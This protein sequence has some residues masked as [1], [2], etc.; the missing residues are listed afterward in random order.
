MPDEVTPTSPEPPTPPPPPARKPS[1]ARNF[2]STVGAIIS[3]IAIANIVFLVFADVL[4]NHAN[5]YAGILAYMVLPAV[6]VAGFVL[7]VLGMILERRRRRRHAPDAIPQYPMIDLNNPN[8]RRALIFSIIGGS[9]FIIVSVLG[10][11][12]AYEFTDSDVFCGA[13]CHQVMHPEYAAYKA[14][15]H[16]RVGCVNCHVGTGA[17][18]YVRSKM[19]GAYQVYAT[20]FNRYPRPIPSPVENLRP[21]Q[22]TCEQCHWPQKFW[23]AQ[24]KVFNH[25]GYDETN[26]P[27]ETQM[28]IKTGGGNPV[29]GAA[30]GI[31]WHMNIANEVYYITTDRQRQKIPWVRIKDPQGHVT[32][33]LAQDANL[34]PAQIA[35]APKRRMDCV[36]C[37]N[38]PTHIYVPPDRSVD[39]AIVAGKI[40]RTLPFVKKESVTLLTK[41]YQST[42]QGVAAI[43]RE[44]TDFYAKNYPDVLENRRADVDAAVKSTQQIFQTTIFPEM[45][46]D[47]RVHPD[48]VGHLYFTGCFRCHD[49]Q[50]VSKDGKIIAKDCNICHTVLGQKE[51]QTVMVETPN[52][53][54][55]HPVDIGDLRAMVCADCHTGA[56]Q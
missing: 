48:N 54:F 3:V 36:D 30:A 50:H 14:S 2:A 5:P 45:H 41:E 52:N 35:A 13:L 33:Y 43:A 6:M 18:W 29:S 27:R 16:A 49:D 53:T 32:E 42:P 46:V 12:R 44:M 40:S 8:H 19:S 37:H 38:R 15:P 55:V 1:L 39:R 56:A 28:L 20:A 51:S 34:T 17:G 21:A 26:T 23:G 11:Y 22:E 9:L 10:S 7:I 25:F 47:W 24:L 4:G 31:H